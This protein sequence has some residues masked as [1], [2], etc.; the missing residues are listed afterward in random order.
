M[1][2]VMRQDYFENR[3]D[4]KGVHEIKCYFVNH[5][6]KNAIIPIIIYLA[7]IVAIILTGSFVIEKIFSIPGNREGPLCKQV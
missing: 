2:E 7:P 1:L 6:L 4:R 3:Q 5:A